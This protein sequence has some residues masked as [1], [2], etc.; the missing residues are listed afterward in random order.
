VPLSRRDLLALAAGASLPGCKRAPTIPGTIRGASMKVGHR[1]RD[2][3]P[4]RASGPPR[5]VKVAIVGGGP[6]GLSAAWRLERAGEKDY[7][8]F[9]LE[10]QPGGT[11]TFG[12]DG[13]TPYPWGAHYVPA[14][15]RHNRALV[16]LLD[17]MGAFDGK[18]ERGDPRVKEELVVREPEERLF[19]ADIWQQGLFPHTIAGPDDRA[20]LERFQ[21]EV[22]A[23]V[24]FRDGQGRRA[25]TLPI[26]RSSD[27]AKVTELDRQSAA[28]W[29]GA[30]GFRS[31]LLRWY[32]E[33][34]CRDDYGLSLA[35]TSA[36]A[37]M[38]YFCA[39]VPAPRQESAPFVSWPEGNGHL[40]RHLTGVAGA[41]VKLGALVTDVVPGESSVDLAV[42]DVPTGALSRWQA[43]Q[44]IL[45]LPKFVV[46]RV[47]RPFRDAPPAHLRDFGYGVWWVANIHLRRRPKSVGFPFAWDNV[48]YDSKSLGYVVATHQRQSDYGPTVWTYYQPMVDANPA[49]ARGHLAEMTH[50]QFVAQIL[51]DLVPAHEGLAQAVERI[52]VWRWGHAMVR[53]V[54]GFI[55]GGARKKAMEP[56]G[57]VH[58]AHCDLS[59][60]ALF[61]E[62]Q[63]HGVRAG[64]EVLARLGRD[65][66]SLR[67]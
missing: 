27:D 49:E 33:Y 60:V 34:A 20:E 35:D 63:D 61:E 48:I 55:W 5:R 7:A 26:A 1:L 54:P 65:V 32:V 42:L 52:D 8:V 4:E 39:R 30:R 40:V 57:R 47:L 29:L 41:R 18:D 66:E 58:F 19:V 24:G 43:E 67:G 25:F 38:F 36:W 21:R 22:D 16:T 46:P 23:W 14:P 45:A 28:D 9:E 62:A 6:S 10:P 56:Y 3:T 50:P 37:L 2:A 53:P 13:V 12:T 59:G 51:A 64:E 44:V 17:E 11:S 15:S 31:K